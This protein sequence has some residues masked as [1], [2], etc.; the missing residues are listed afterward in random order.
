[1][2]F[3][4]IKE[5]FFCRKTTKNFIM[6]TVLLL[7][8]STIF[9]FTPI[10]IISQ[11]V[12][13]VIKENKTV[14]VDEVFD[15]IQAQT[16]YTFIYRSNMFKDFPLV[17]L[18][19]SI[20]RVNDLL[21]SAI[22]NDDYHFELLKH[23]TI[24]IEKESEISRVIQGEITGKVTDE[25]NTPLVG[26][27][28]LVKGTKKGVITDF[29]G[30]Y[31]INTLKTSDILIFSSMGFQE[32]E[33]KVGKKRVINVV[34]KQSSNEL[35]EI[36][37]SG[38]RVNSGYQVLSKAK[39]IGAYVVVSSKEIETKVQ[40]NILER[41]EGTVSGLS[42]FRG[43]PV[44][45]GIST[46]NGETYPLIVLDGVPYE[47]SLESIHPNDIENVTVLKDAT[48]AS[49]YGVRSA[50]G[51]I[52]VTSK[53]GLVG[54]PRFSYTSTIQAT[55]LPDRSYE[56]LM[57]S[58]EF[59]D[60]QQ[61]IFDETY[62]PGTRYDI[63]TPTPL[64]EVNKLLYA[65]AQGTIS[66]SFLNSELTR[67]KSLDGYTQI[68]DELLNARFTQQHNFSVRGGSEAHQYSIS[69]NFT[70]IGSYEKDNS[71][72]R[73]GINAKNY[74]KF[75]DWLKTDIGV[76]ANY[77]S[78]DNYT[79]ISGVALLN[80]SLPYQMLKDEDGNPNQWERYKSFYEVERLKE[81]GLQD[82]S[83][84]PLNEKNT[85]QV[86]NKNPSAII[87]IGAKVN[88]TKSLSLDFRA[89]TEMGKSSS[90]A[91]STIE[92]HDIR[93]LLNNSSAVSNGSITNY[94]PIGGRIVDSYTDRRSYTLRGQL[95]YAKLFSNKHDVKVLLGA[96]KRKSTSNG[97]GYLGYGYDENNLSTGNVLREYPTRS[98]IN[99]TQSL[100]GLYNFSN[101][102]VGTVN[103]DRYISLYGN[104]SYMFDDK[105]GF[106]VNARIDQSNL[107]G[108][109][110]KYKYRP[111]WSVGANYIIDVESTSWLDK[112]KIRAT[113]GISGNV[114]N[115]SSPE[116][117]VAYSG[118]PSYLSGEDYS[119]ISSPPNES[120]RWEK[121]NITNLGIDYQMFSNRI[122]GSFEWYNKSTVDIIGVIP[123]D[124]ILGWPNLPRNYASMY[125]RGIELQIKSQNIVGENF[126]WRSNFIF[127][128]NN[129]QITDINDI[130]ETTSS[131]N[132]SEVTT[133]DYLYG[134]NENIKG[135][136]RNSLYAI[137]YAG[138]NDEGQP[139]AYKLDGTIVDSRND[140]DPE[141]LVFSG[142]YDPPY[143][144][145]LS[146]DITFKQFDLSFL[147]I[148]YGG[149]VQRDVASGYYPIYS[150]PDDLSTNLDKMVGNYW[151]EPGDEADIYKF[152]VNR[153]SIK[154]AV[155]NIWKYGDIHVQKADYVKLRNVSLT[156]NLP[157]P[158][159]DK[160]NISR[161]NF[162]FDV[163]NPLSWFANKNNLDP[164]A[165]TGQ[166]S[167][168]TAVMPTYTFG[169]NLNF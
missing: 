110:P 114:Y 92:N 96:E 117:I 13:I 107:F 52:V 80:S 35:D 79:G 137:R 149:H 127:N 60:Y 26:V 113:H 74:F 139:T 144:L 142:T 94:I 71:V 89:Q 104:A 16:E 37:I 48:A 84:F 30:K 50:N 70:S 42:L 44:V 12:K 46:L 101:Q 68:E 45:R 34:L 102:P 91:L 109:N 158:F 162:V 130:G 122:S 8:C 43:V 132:P 97:Y 124:P 77:S 161:L 125:N 20:I 93:S 7:F 99:G 49:I 118:G 120:L 4:F 143:H 123:S 72:D 17:T 41:L 129:N 153:T 128:Y 3:N 19:K 163:R 138:L 165:W 88:L 31:I 11:N 22:S 106:N 98:W 152:P 159:L 66:E 141:D 32:K 145:S 81:L 111:L 133:T 58:S 167:R 23:N 103:D 65:H 150:S 1:M 53:K 126:S 40:T 90:R 147:I 63:R 160:A 140:L 2:N 27:T 76:I 116:L 39:S 121:T 28:V 5:F 21:S 169:I 64:D 55:D 62:E 25:N 164:E 9:S 112:L 6:R 10:D 115:G 59:I 156:Y 148:Y 36:V 69:L 38:K 67:L 151:Q 54:K 155:T 33:I 86:I 105:L 154:S 166:S 87:N 157:K 51:V 75:N 168:G 78:S 100:S 61:Y 95:N 119:T 47:G 131:D 135:K 56:N 24:V 83:Y 14:T 85:V 82:E 146:N 134:E 108:T 73:V 15:I 57:S 136:P 18:N 29:D